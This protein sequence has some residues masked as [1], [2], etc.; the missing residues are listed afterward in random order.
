MQHKK[1]QTA[2]NVFMPKKISK[3]LAKKERKC[4]NLTQNVKD[5]ERYAMKKRFLPSALL[6]LAAIIWGFAFVAQRVGADYLGA[7]AFGGIRFTLG[8]IVLIPVILLFDRKKPEKEEW[9]HLI[10]W[11][12]IA[13]AI[14]FSGSVM[15]Q[16][17]LQ[18]SGSAGK[19][20][21][22]TGLYTVLVPVCAV[23]L[24]K[25]IHKLTWV[26]VAC[27]VV[28]LY[29]V[30][31]GGS[32][33]FGQG[34][35]ITLVST[36]VWTGHILVIDAAAKRVNPL[37]LSCGQFLVCGMLSLCCAA[38][39]EEVTFAA[40]ESALIPLLYGGLLSVGVGFTLQTVGQKRADPTAASI[41]MSTESVFGAIGGALILKERMSWYGYLG[42]TLM[43]TGIILAQLKQPQENY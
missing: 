36:F 32:E 29:L 9:K 14:L 41:I 10:F 8:G 3:P 16:F 28:G 20:S 26:G 2:K 39:F 1:R 38:L 15:Q 24:G 25:R 5:S 31:V 23:F 42:C 34:D 43:F 40:I 22:I 19:V 18:W 7:F 6:L 33:S 4:Y 21:F 12:L 11:S 35:I 30:C 17:G 13:G 37:W 27:A